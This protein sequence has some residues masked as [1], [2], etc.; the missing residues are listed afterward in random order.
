MG[1]PQKSE[2]RKL[3][4]DSSKLSELHQERMVDGKDFEDKF[5]FSMDAYRNQTRMRRKI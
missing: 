3:E 5:R 4:L 1:G 2:F